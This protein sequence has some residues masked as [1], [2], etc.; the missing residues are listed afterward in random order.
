M[1]NG[2][3]GI[4]ALL[5]LVILLVLSTFLPFSLTKIKA[6]SN[7]FYEVHPN[8]IIV[9][10]KDGTKS[11]SVKNYI[12]D[13]L[14]L[15]KL[16]LVKK[17]AKINPDDNEDIEVLKLDDN[18]DM[19]IVLKE[20]KSNKFVKYAE[21]NAFKVNLCSFSSNPRSGE[22]WGLKNEG[23]II[24]GVTG[25]NTIDTNILDAWN[26]FSWNND[27]TVAVLDTGMDIS[28]PDI[29]SNINTNGW[30]F[31]NDRGSPLYDPAEDTS[32]HANHVAGIIAACDNT[33][34]II[35]TAPQAT[36]LPLKVI[37]DVVQLCESSW[38][39]DAIRYAN[40]AGAKIVNMSFCTDENNI[41]I[42]R[43]EMITNSNMIFVCA[44]GNNNVDL[45][46]TPYYP[47]AW[48]LSNQITVGAIDNLGHK[49]SYSN[50]GSLVHIA[51]PGNDILSIVPNNNYEYKSGTSMAAP[52]ISG[53]L[54]LKLS[55]YPNG[56]V[57][58][59]V[60]TIKNSV[61]VADCIKNTFAS[62]GLGGRI[63]AYAV[64]C[65]SGNTFYGDV[66]GTGDCNSNDIA[67]IRQYILHMIAD[68]PSPNGKL[69]ADVD[70]DGYINSLD[71]SYIER[72][73]SRQIP[74]FPV[75]E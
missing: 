29:S 23:Q 58:Q 35:G 67:Y 30:D 75:E 47:A 36:I 73:I 13:K 68:F 31:A 11:A 24:N 7:K 19:D 3:V 60:S 56:T 34:G 26:N 71:W 72:Y 15:S 57:A 43:D 45:N 33:I 53:I 37:V 42:I 28:H 63:N 18:A 20:F 2:K 51:A 64:L 25:R 66:D 10:Y 38:V 61:I 54:A 22:Q 50:Y 65:Q 21:P 12:M 27:V 48:N 6:E 41:N 44:A 4:K 62:N 69:A 8:E 40:Q 16:D 5:L 70:G 14:N 74:R 9:K 55:Y 46:V 32:G 1:L 39:V 59:Y 49:A 17:L 52:Y